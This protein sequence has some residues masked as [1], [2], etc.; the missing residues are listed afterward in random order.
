MRKRQ[1]HPKRKGMTMR[2][3]KGR[4]IADRFR[5]VKSGNLYL[6]PSQSGKGKYKVDLQA[7]TCS[8]PDF[9]YTGA[10]CK[11]QNG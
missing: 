10:K 11:H 7:N 8:C 3:L 5:I 6:V 9:E 1:K 2:E 4:D